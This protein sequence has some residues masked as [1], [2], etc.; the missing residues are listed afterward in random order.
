VENV[1]GFAHTYFCDGRTNKYK[2]NVRWNKTSVCH[3]LTF[4]WQYSYWNMNM[5][6]VKFRIL[7]YYTEIR[8]CTSICCDFNF[9]DIFLLS[10]LISCKYLLKAFTLQ[11]ILAN[12]CLLGS[13]WKYPL[14]P[15]KVHIYR[16]DKKKTKKPVITI[17]N[18]IHSY[19]YLLKHASLYLQCI[20]LVLPCSYFKYFCRTCSWNKFLWHVTK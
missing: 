14:P 1:G 2:Y 4:I 15:H 20:L 17:H 7:V 11:T 5:K 18:Q 13:E 16:W 12:F 8:V 9:T 3:L 10:V 6:A 19:Q